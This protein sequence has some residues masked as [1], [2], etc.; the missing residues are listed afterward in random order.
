MRYLDYSMK[1]RAPENQA[2]FFSKA[3]VAILIHNRIKSLATKVY[4]IF[5][6]VVSVKDTEYKSSKFISY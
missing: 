6:R 5:D 4:A 1:N 3:E 2:T